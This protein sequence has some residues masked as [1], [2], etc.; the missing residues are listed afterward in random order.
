MAN[1]PNKKKF[2]VSSVE[3]QKYFA[4][5]GNANRAE[6]ELNKAKRHLQDIGDLILD[7]QGIDPRAVKDFNLTGLDLTIQFKT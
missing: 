2:V 3:S 4:A 1:K 6:A 7:R 5:L